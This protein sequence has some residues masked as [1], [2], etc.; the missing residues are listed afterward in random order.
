VALIGLRLSL[1]GREELV[2]K[3]KFFFGSGFGFIFEG[4]SELGRKRISGISAMDAR[5]FDK[6]RLII[7]G[8]VEALLQK[9]VFFASSGKAVQTRQGGVLFVVNDIDF[10]IVFFFWACVLLQESRVFF[11]FPS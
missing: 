7:H 5:G 2:R 10:H 1:G 8:I 4:I 9:V 6:N 11:Y 3:R